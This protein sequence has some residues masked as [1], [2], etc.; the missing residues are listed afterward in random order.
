MPDT[1]KA[2]GWK[3][4]EVEAVFNGCDCTEEC[5]AEDT[6]QEDGRF[7]VLETKAKELMDAGQS[8]VRV[9]L[10]SSTCASRVGKDG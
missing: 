4:F 5:A 8:R 10:C 7:E 9:Q 6:R 3:A 1:S 2:V